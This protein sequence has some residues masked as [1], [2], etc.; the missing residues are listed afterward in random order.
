MLEAVR[1]KLIELVNQIGPAISEEPSLCERFFDSR[2]KET[3]KAIDALVAAIQQGVTSELRQA[4][5]ESRERISL[6]GKV[7][8]LCSVGVEPEL[9]SWAIETWAIAMGVSDR[10]R[11]SVDFKCPACEARGVSLKKIAG[12]TITCPRCKS[13]VCVSIDGA[14]F[15]VDLEDKP[16]SAEN[17]RSSRSDLVYPTTRIAT[18]SSSE[19][20]DFSV[21]SARSNESIDTETNQTSQPDMLKRQL[22]AI[23]SKVEP[24]LDESR[25]RPAI[26][27]SNSIGMQ[28]KLIFPGNFL[29]GDATRDFESTISEPFYLGVHPVT[30]KQYEEVIGRNPSRFRGPGNPVE[31]V[32]W[33]DAV[34]FCRELSNLCSE[35]AENLTY[36]LPTESEWEYACRAGS[37]SDYCYGNDPSQ[38]FE[39][40]WFGNNFGKGPRYVGQ[41]K[42]NAWGL[43]DMHGNVSE[44]CASRF[45]DYPDFSPDESRDG[46]D[47]SKRTYRG[48]HW[49]NQAKFCR[50]AVRHGEAPGFWSDYLGFRVA[51]SV[52]RAVL[53]RPPMQALP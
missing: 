7:R 6:E 11:Y 47:D 33:H 35:I 50:S 5:Q 25:N 27:F 41:K 31:C 2:D 23:L 48:G 21:D 39:Y 30:Q 29:M 3:T 22:P 49:F 34:S 51:V 18:R 46:M 19:A 43:Y 16:V 38:L 15:T 44:W 4:K 40:A 13:R 20:P 42:P 9:A 37:D 26:E 32:S 24:V 14:T 52:H 45:A 36:R 10:V 12:R 8:Q 1:E 17:E 53:L 28:F